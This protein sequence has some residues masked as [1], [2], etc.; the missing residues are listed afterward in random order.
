MRFDQSYLHLKEK[1]KHNQ[2]KYS[3]ISKEIHIARQ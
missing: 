3:F 1:L 2:I